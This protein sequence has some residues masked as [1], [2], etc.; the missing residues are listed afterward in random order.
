MFIF[1]PVPCYICFVYSLNVHLFV[2]KHNNCNKNVTT[3]ICKQCNTCRRYLNLVVQLFTP[4]TKTTSVIIGVVMERNK[5]ENATYL[6]RCHKNSEAMTYADLTITILIKS[7]TYLIEV[8]FF[9]VLRKMS[10]TGNSRSAHLFSDSSK[11][12]IINELTYWNCSSLRW[13]DI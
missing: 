7:V 12:E 6:E 2:Q 1:I 5:C 4:T 8:S 10:E 3:C 13:C 9:N 11:V